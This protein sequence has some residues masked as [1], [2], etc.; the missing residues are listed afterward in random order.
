MR[1]YILL[2]CLAAFGIRGGS[3]GWSQSGPGVETNSNAGRSGTGGDQAAQT[4]SDSLA[5]WEGLT[6]R[7]ISFE[8]VAADRLVPLPGHLSQ[9]EGAPLNREQLK[10]S[11]RQLFATG[12]YED[13]QVEGER[14]M[15]G[16]DLVFSGQPRTFIGTVSVDGARGAT[17]NTQLE[18]ASQLAPGTRYT[19]ARLNLA[20]E[21]M[22]RTL[23]ENGF[24]EPKIAHTL[25]PHPDEQLVDIAFHVTSG[26][27]ARVGAVE[28]TGDPGMSAEVFRR[29]A[30]LRAGSRVDHDTGN[31]AL[32]GVLK[33]YQGQERLEAEI[34]LESERY[35][36]E[37][38]RADFRF[39]ANRGPQVRVL[40]EGAGMGLERMKKVIPIFEEG[41]VDDDL[42]NEGNR[43]LREYYQRLG[44]FD[45]KV[46]HEQ[47]SA[48]A[49]QVV[50]LYTVSLGP[51]R[52][53]ERVS[54]AGNRYFDSAT[55]KELLSVHAA[56]TL[57]RHG[58]Y[59]QALVSADVAPCRP[60]IRTTA[61]PKVKI[62][63]ET[64]VA[65]IPK[66]AAQAESG[67]RLNLAARA[68]P[69]R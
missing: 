55:L 24:H 58:A 28:V 39:S 4:P 18:R 1:Y 17:V 53:V 62:T 66:P 50:I 14:Q 13:I 46:E 3:D 16:V 12:L 64:S 29:A 25:T 44:Y 9:A 10:S 69:P 21:E 40:V 22:R 49:E 35:A 2:A 31:R 52:R 26:P 60:S 41:A 7:R 59:S 45:V 48:T 43:R 38:M 15:D 47:Q 65:E 42:L 67:P 6:V 23:A 11:L 30:H 27:Q 63:P 33:K 37:T 19:P 5:R 57:D 51:R 54:V 32:G 34:K 68:R 20:L 56:D 61:S 8:G 36:A